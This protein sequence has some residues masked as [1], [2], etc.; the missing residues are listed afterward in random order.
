MSKQTAAQRIAAAL[1]ITAEAIR[2]D[3]LSR[4]ENPDELM[5]EAAA[6]LRRLEA[7][8]VVLLKSLRIS[9]QFMSIAMDWNIDEAEIDGEMRSTRH[10]LEIIRT[11]IAKHESRHED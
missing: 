5:T 8:N 1:Y 4:W 10:W 3:F 6:E 7:T 9:E 2:M 11:S